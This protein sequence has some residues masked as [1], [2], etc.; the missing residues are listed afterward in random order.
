MSEEKKQVK[1][2]NPWFW[3]PTLYFAQGLPYVAVMTISVIMYKR[4]GMS[5][6]DIALYTGWLGLPWVIKPFWSPFVDIIRT[7]RWWVLIMQ[8]IVAFAL[9]GIAFTIP[10]AWWVQLTF[11]VFML[12]GFASATHDIAADGFYMLALSEHEQSLYVGIRSTFYRIATVFGQGILVILAGLIEMNSGL[13]PVNI[14]I[15]A[16][17]NVPA[18]TAT[19]P[20]VSVSDADAKGDVRFI[21]SDMNTIK[22]SVKSVSVVP[23]NIAKTVAT[24]TSDRTSANLAFKDYAK[25]IN[26]SIQNSNIHNGFYVPDPK[27]ALEM[28]VVLNEKEYVVQGYEWNKAKYL[29]EYTMTDG[30]KAI[31]SELK[32][33]ESKEEKSGFENW[34]ATTFPDKYKNAS[35]SVDDNFVVVAVRLNKKPAKDEEY[36]LNVSNDKGS[37]DIKVEQSRFVFNESNWDKPAYIRFSID[38][39]IKD[40]VALS[41]FVATSGNI[42]LAWSIVFVTLSI[43][44][45][46]VVLYHTWAMPK[47]ATDDDKEKQ[48]VGEIIHGFV[49][50]FKTFFTKFPF[51]QTFA[52]IMFM[53]FYRFP[54]AQLTKI[55]MPFLVDPLDKGGLALSTSQVGIV[56]GTIGII[57][58]TIG[59]IVGGIVAAKGGLKKWLQP[60]AWSMS[61]TCLTFIYLAFT[62]DQS[63][64]TINICVFI[65]QFGYGFGFTAYMLYLIYYSEGKY[66]TAHYAICTGF[67]ALSMMM[68]MMAGWLEDLIGYENFFI[69]TIICCAAT[70]VVS[71][72]VKVDPKFG[73]KEDDAEN[74]D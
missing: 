60:M 3:I 47:P 30:T 42:P 9:A 22:T 41:S 23:E 37:T 28:A 33:K 63:M 64:I 69:W 71:M 15:E 43:F 32:V 21:V 66:K 53:L 59:G 8:W 57:G 16:N 40:K 18:V 5:N 73:L 56:Y 36:V 74:K 13:D 35:S 12:M 62:Q 4:L 2:R 34:I 31:E 48:S 70:I 38:H 44:F 26:D 6:T 17:P 14:S 7:K 45:F 61:L 19:L 1:K 49:D 50:T 51:W 10:T 25:V 52:A 68:G 54:E 72:I 55:I 11:A 46:C 27:F 65:E 29:Y 39:K 67:M 24:Q 58:L 20:T